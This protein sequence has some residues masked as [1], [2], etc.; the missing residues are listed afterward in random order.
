MPPS[1]KEFAAETLQ[2]QDVPRPGL[3]GARAWQASVIGPKPAR[4]SSHTK[5]RRGVEKIAPR[6][7]V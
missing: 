3:R 5:A 2:R 4:M 6:F 1:P 7:L